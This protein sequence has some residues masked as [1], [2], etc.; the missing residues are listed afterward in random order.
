MEIWKDF[1]FNQF[2]GFAFKEGQLESSIHLEGDEGLPV[3]E[4]LENIYQDIRENNF[5]HV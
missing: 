1:D 5:T 4:L 3:Q 2:F